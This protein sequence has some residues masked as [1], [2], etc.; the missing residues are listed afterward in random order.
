MA[1][2]EVGVD[3]ESPAACRTCREGEEEDDAFP[4]VSYPKRYRL[5]GW[6]LGLG[7]VIPLPYFFY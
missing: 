6:S 3:V 7:Q 5:M 1:V 2:A 4:S